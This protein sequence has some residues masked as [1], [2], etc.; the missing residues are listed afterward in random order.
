MVLAAL[1]AGI[2]KDDY[3]TGHLLAHF[4]SHGGELLLCR[5]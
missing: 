4:G 2:E 3:R 5:N 1:S